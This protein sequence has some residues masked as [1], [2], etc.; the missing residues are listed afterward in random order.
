MRR[1]SLNPGP[2]N[3]GS[4]K[5]TC[6]G[7]KASLSLEHRRSGWEFGAPPNTMPGPKSPP[8]LTLILPNTWWLESL[9][10]L[11][12]MDVTSS[13]LWELWSSR[14]SLRFASVTSKV[15]E[16]LKKVVDSGCAPNLWS[17]FKSWS[18]FLK[19]LS[20]FA[21]VRWPA[22]RRVGCSTCQCRDQNIGVGPLRNSDARQVSSSTTE[23][24]CGKP[25][26]TPTEAF[27]NIR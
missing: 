14:I 1:N 12:L 21:S 22:I 18:E 10:A 20:L 25:T 2:F 16:V 13:E 17:R 15:A 19:P 9:G 23:V 3:G 11:V 8:R 26:R 7:L 4:R 6:F 24:I 27:S 5:A